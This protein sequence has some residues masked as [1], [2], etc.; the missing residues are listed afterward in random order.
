VENDDFFYLG[1]HVETPRFS[2][3]H[4]KFQAVAVPKDE[5]LRGRDFRFII[6]IYLH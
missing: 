3:T 5:L 2:T 4:K 1:I 6:E